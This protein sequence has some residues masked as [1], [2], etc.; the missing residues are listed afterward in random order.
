[1][2]EHKIFLF[3]PI[4]LLAGRDRVGDIVCGARGVALFPF[5]HGIQ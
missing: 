2:N 5:L 3:C 1:V 4:S